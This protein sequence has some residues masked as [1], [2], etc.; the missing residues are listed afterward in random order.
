MKGR[1]V[2]G[3]EGPKRPRL[4]LVGE[5]LGAEEEAQGRPFVGTDGGILDGIL[6]SARISR[7]DLY[8][9]NVIKVRPP[10]NK[11]ERLYEYGLSV[12]DFIPLLEQ[13]LSEVECNT[14][15][16]IGDLALNIL[17]KKDGITKHRGSIYEAGERL[18]VPTLHPGH[19]REFWQ[20]RGTVVE[21]LKKAIRVAKDGYHP[22]EFNTLI[23]PTITEIED[24][25]KICVESKV[26]VFDLETVGSTISCVGLGTL[27]HGQR[28]SLCIPMKHG[29]NNYWS[30][31][32]ECYIW[33]WLRQ[34]FQTECLKIAQ[35]ITFDLTFL[36]PFIGEP[37]PPWYDLMVA[38]HTVDPELPH[39]LAYMTSIYTDIPYYKDDPKD[40]DEGWSYKTP[41][42]VLWGYNGKDCEGPLIIEPQLTEEMKELRV[43]D[44]YYG[45]AMPLVRVMY[46]MQRRGLKVDK[47]MQAKLLEERMGSLARKQTELNYRVGYDLNV[48]SPKQMLK[49]LYEDLKL[50]THKNRKTGRPTANKET[51]EKLFAKHPD[52][53]F[54]LVME[55]RDLSKDIGTY[56]LAEPDEDG[57][58]RGRYNTTGTETGRSS[59]SKTIFDT[60][61]DLQNIPPDL[62][63]MFMAGEGKV[64]MMYDLWQAEAFVVA[65]L[66]NAIAL[67]D[68]LTRGEKVHL[69]VASWLFNK[70]EGE[71][72]TVSKNGEMSEYDK[73]KR[74]VHASHYGLGYR[75]LSILLKIPEWEAKA[76]LLKYRQYVP[77]IDAWHLEV[78][79]ELKRSR[80]LVTPFGRV[81]F[82]RNRYGEDMG[83]EAFAHVP[84]STIG[85]LTH[86]AML[87][88]EYSLPKDARL[89]QEGFDSIIIEAPLEQ[90]NYIKEIVKSSFDKTLFWKGQSFK[91]PFDE[92]I[93][94]RWE[95]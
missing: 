41:S 47:E 25:T 90:E 78:M 38:H 92:K 65:I 91:I 89:V 67:K 53:R 76:F 77:E 14:I 16:P 55:L 15:V 61:L 26:F 39:D 28:V 7:S 75:L 45:F 2:V 1:K 73:A 70:S 60:G 93:S 35:N 57:R 31:S 59:C 63:P 33:G 79:E 88:M 42:E 10:N 22:V 6:T 32:D 34:L 9:S 80:K 8:I 13:E 86:Q 74:V 58:F 43:L 83:R 66:A 54:Q 37:S 94:K 12:E 51:L 40:K 27:D 95:K 52:P 46:R 20:S 56:L 21:D 69:M 50:P 4:I 48:N 17:L 23:R 49:F 24:F 81:R 3:G 29:L 82:F 85:D 11:V 72:S 18:A 64:F 36:A 44:F 30:H 71:V 68:K 19:V 84:Q 5:S 87:Q 62:R